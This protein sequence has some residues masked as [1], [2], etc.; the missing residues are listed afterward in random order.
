MA[1]NERFMPVPP[2]A[3]WEVL[4]DPGAYGYWVVGSKV[5]RDAEPGWPEPEAKFHHTIGIGPFKTSDHTVSLEADR[6]RRLKMRAK[7][8]PFGSA[9]VTL[10]LRPEAD[11]TVV[12]MTENAAGPFALFALNPVTHLTTSARNAESL[13]R[14]EELALRRAAPRSERRQKSTRRAQAPSTA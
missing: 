8:R 6:P 10:E 12:Q 2:E 1:T 4:A 13:M 7:G 5:I 11:G 9:T 14:L 3:V